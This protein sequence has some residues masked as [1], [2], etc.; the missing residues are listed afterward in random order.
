MSEETILGAP[1]MQQHT[2]GLVE[3]YTAEI[4]EWADAKVPPILTNAEYAARTSALLIALSRQLGRAAAAFGEA[5]S[6]SAD[7]V[8]ELVVSMFAKHHTQSL[9]AIEIKE[10]I[11]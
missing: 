3:A 10:T 2:S 1:T 6:V 9:Q 4:T 8:G 11:Q 5:Q 7:E